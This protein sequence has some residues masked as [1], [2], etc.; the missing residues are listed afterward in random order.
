MTE[1]KQFILGLLELSLWPFI[2]ITVLLLFRGPMLS[3]LNRA[4]S[5]KIK[6]PSGGTIELETSEAAAIVEGV[7]EGIDEL[8]I[9]MGEEEKAL[10]K[11]LSLLSA[12][13]KVEEIFPDFKRSTKDIQSNNH[14][15]LGVLAEAALN[16][17]RRR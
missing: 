1:N 17:A 5:L 16:S 3:L 14:V 13:P 10:M 8:I 2:A 12:P 4:K 9:D 15:T 7:L 11:K 6:V